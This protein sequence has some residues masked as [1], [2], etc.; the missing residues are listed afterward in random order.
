MKLPRNID[1]AALIAAL[2]GLGY[3]V[4]RQKGS[5][6]RVTTQTGGEHNETI[7]LHRP[8]KVGTLTAILKSI[9][10]HHKLTVA[11]L[12]RKLDI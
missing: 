1:G 8:L 10:S 6:V 7:P 4:T 5:H 9:A 3:G 12:V 11:D 2:K